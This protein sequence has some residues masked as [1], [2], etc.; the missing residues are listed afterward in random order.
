[1]I[2][3]TG[4]TGLIGAHL[5]LQLSQKEK[6]IRAIY[7][8]ANKIADVKR[9]FS[10]EENGD[11]LF[12]Q[13]EWMEAD[14][15]NVTSLEKAF[16]DISKVFHCAGFIS[17]DPFDYKSLRNINIEGTAN[18][19]NLCIAHK[20]EKLCYL[21]SIAT[22]GDKT[23]E[24][25]VDEETHWDPETDNSIYAI[26][27][28]GAEMEVWRGTQEGV[29]AIIL[30]PGV[31][32]GEGFWDSPSSQIFKKVNEGLSYY[33]SGSS[34]FVDVK[35]VVQALVKSMDSEIKNKRF[36]TVG[37]N[38]SYKT[39]VEHIAKALQKT[40]PKKELKPWQ[41]NL[42]WRIDWFLSLFPVPGRKRK[43]TRKT[44]KSLSSKTVYKN[45]KIKKALA[46]DFTPIEQTIGRIS[47]RFIAS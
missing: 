35:D 29:P 37:S 12:N 4:G 44:A 47:K 1:M 27:K 24:K 25:T 42:L 3:V 17:F 14:I 39:I 32:L 18:I 46:I 21:S 15:T 9:F 11:T 22:L 40:P 38:I 30:N 2:L 31:V 8:N 41:I 6:T 19:V 7:R 34:G 45:E 23:G 16:E 26:T 43:L 33:T 5:L 36:V 28:Y 13:I 20:I 10:A